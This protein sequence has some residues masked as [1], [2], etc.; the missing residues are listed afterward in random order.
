MNLPNKLTTLRV[1][2]I[3]FFV[4]F[5]LM[6]DIPYNYIIACVIFCLA[7]I[8]DALDGHIAR[9]RNLITNFG[10]FMDPLADKL[11]V[12][13]ALICFLKVPGNPMPAWVVIVIIAREFIISG[14]RLV[15]SDAGVVIAASYWGKVK[16]VTQMVMSILLIL[17][18]DHPVVNVVELVLIYLACLLTVISLVDYIAKNVNVLKEDKK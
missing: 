4:F 14:F 10:K 1:C 18:I 15:A 8:T 9:S 13:S 2:M 17:N 11:L 7:S 12:C 6:P 5:M 3:P 16:T